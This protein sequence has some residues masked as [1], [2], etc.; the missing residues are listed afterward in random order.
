MPTGMGKP[1]ER[2]SLSTAAQYS[3]RRRLGNPASDRRA[4][5]EGVIV[6][7]DELTRRFRMVANDETRKRRWNLD[8]QA[9]RQAIELLLY[10][11]RHARSNINGRRISELPNRVSNGPLGM[12]LKAVFSDATSTVAR[13]LKAQLN[14]MFLEEDECGFEVKTNGLSP[15]SPNYRVIVS[16]N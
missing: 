4:E 8:I 11:L 2:C 5:T 6:S 12:A 1:Q 14:K 15:N 7:R 13:S 3:A 9:A 10:H 16:I